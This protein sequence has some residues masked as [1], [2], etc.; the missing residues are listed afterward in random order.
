[1]SNALT[2]SSD[3]SPSCQLWHQWLWTNGVLI[4]SLVLC[5]SLVIAVRQFSGL[6]GMLIAAS[7]LYY[8]LLGPVAWLERR[9][10]KRL[11]RILSDKLPLLPRGIA[12]ILVL[13]GVTLLLIIFL[14]T[15]LPILIDRTTV[16]L[17]KLPS[18]M[19]QLEAWIH[20]GTGWLQNTLTANIQTQSPKVVAH[21]SSELS[22]LLTKEALA[23]LKQLGQVAS[24][25]AKGAIKLG[26]SGFNLF[27]Y[28]FSAVMIALFALLDG[29]QLRNSFVDLL[30]DPWEPRFKKFLDEVHVHMAA[31]IRGQLVL[32]IL[33]SVFVY[34][35][36][37]ALGV[38]HALVLSLAFGSFSLVPVIGPWLGWLPIVL[39]VLFQPYEPQN[40]VSVLVPFV[41]LFSMFLAVKEYLIQPMVLR[42]IIRMNPMA[43][44][45]TF[46]LMLHLVGLGA[47]W[48][49]LPLAAFFTAVYKSLFYPQELPMTI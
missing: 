13:I 1:M 43:V 7:V 15:G 42:P 3:A 37:S 41:A 24:D 11:P 23:W 33:S 45:L 47:F 14:G 8:L 27:L 9:F 28:G 12:L 32:A 2:H 46:L 5:L 21:W 35:V 29:K 36:A 10:L 48:M 6:F 49:T 34:A 25:I 31:L 22:N 4:C 17:G 20:Q 44:L 19:E 18:Y 30:P 26:L 39:L 16:L 40:Q 38:P